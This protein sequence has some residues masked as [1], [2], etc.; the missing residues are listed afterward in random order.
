MLRFVFSV[1]AAMLTLGCAATPISRSIAAAP[2]GGAGQ[3]LAEGEA[4]LQRSDWARAEALLARAEQLAPA[5]PR[6]TALRS[7]A[8]LRQGRATD[9]LALARASL[10]KGE[11]A[12]ARLV[13]GRGLAAHRRFEA[14]IASFERCAALDARGD[15]AWGALAAARL[16][17]G[18]AAGAERAYAELARRA[19]ASGAEDRVWTEILQ[20]PPDPAQIQE[21][22]DRCARGTAAYLAG[23]YVEAHYEAAVVL[24]TIG[25]FG[26]CWSELGRA[27]QK[28]GRLE[29]AEQAFRRALSTYRPD[30]APLRADT[31]ALLAAVL[32]ERG[33]VPGEAVTL[34]RD[35]LAVRP[36][37]AATVEVLAKACALAKDASCAAQ[38]G[39]RLGDAA[40]PGSPA[41]P[42]RERLEG[43]R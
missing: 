2:G 42:A 39:T 24:G 16:A 19:G 32:L 3:A 43:E 4:A 38:A 31:E 40:P 36:G 34:A 10:G 13:E 14:A 29:E 18:D 17:V 22:L 6:P 7:L 23:R 41:A 37:R 33:G 35:S 27:S 1:V 28:L 20:M 26:H 30:Q 8:V 21:A 12:E 9:A 25:G 5:A 11:T 15:E